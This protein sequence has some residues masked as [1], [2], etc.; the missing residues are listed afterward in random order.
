MGSLKP[1]ATYIYETANGITYAREFGQD[2]RT[3]I[4]W[5]ME[6][7]DALQKY[8]DDLLWKDIRE[9]AVDNVTLQRALDQ[10]III[11]NLSK[12]QNNGS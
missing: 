4:G 1:G 7:N 3:P 11:Y 2:K 6:V 5:N 9:A 12:E 10:C 8:K